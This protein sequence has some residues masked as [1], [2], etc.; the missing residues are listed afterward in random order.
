[1]DTDRIFENHVEQQY[2]HCFTVVRGRAPEG[3]NKRG[4]DVEAAQVDGGE[5]DI[6]ENLARDILPCSLRDACADVR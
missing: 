3:M 5:R 6:L 1:M 2:S 4:A